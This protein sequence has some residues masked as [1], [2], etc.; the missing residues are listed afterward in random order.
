VL[1]FFGSSVVYPSS[2]A[3]TREEVEQGHGFIVVRKGDALVGWWRASCSNG[4]GVLV[5]DGEDFFA[6]LGIGAI[7]ADSALFCC[8]EVFLQSS[9]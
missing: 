5:R 8:G 6:G 3:P 1:G 9:R 4:N 2:G 7:L